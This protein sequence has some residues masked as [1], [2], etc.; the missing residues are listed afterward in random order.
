MIEAIIFD[1]GGT[2]IEYSGGYTSWPDLET[3]GF[4][5]A[6]RFLC[7]RGV[8]MPELDRFR[9]VGFDLLPGRWR[10]ATSGH[11]NL[12]LED[13][14][15]E[16][17]LNL[18]VPLP[19]A[20]L[21]D[22]A[23]IAYE[24][25]V[26]AEARPIPHGREVVATLKADGYRLGLISNTMFGSRAH[27]NDL[28]RFGLAGFFD[29]MLF[30]ADHNKWKPRPDPFLHVMAELNVTPSE[31]VFVG[32]DP[33]SDVVGGQRVGMKTIY[34]PSSQRFPSPDGV[35]S[36]GR[37]NDLLELPLVLAAFNLAD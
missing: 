23:A 26:R 35:V 12:T 24:D 1:L 37:I 7:D 30:S 13:L 22:G 32:D 16:V 6:H 18:K 14:M 3:P 19:A 4:A 9:L 5:A 8:E 33:A 15:A 31:A 11:R 17:L 2:L 27:I 21:I 28:E 29:T 25:A 20:E 36:D 10:E 34:F